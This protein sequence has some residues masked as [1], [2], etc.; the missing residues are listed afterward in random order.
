MA[1]VTIDLDRYEDLLDTETRVNVAVERII[2]QK[3]IRTE[4]ILRIFGTT[5]AIHEADRLREEDER[6]EK[7][8]NKKHGFSE[9]A[10]A[11]L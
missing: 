10:D 4:D 7:E 5:A 9:N 11:D 6:R 2:N 3:Y 8:W 1:T